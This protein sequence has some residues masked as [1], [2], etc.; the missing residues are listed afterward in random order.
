MKSVQQLKSQF[1]KCLVK[2]CVPGL[3]KPVKRSNSLRCQVVKLRIYHICAAYNFHT[4]VLQ[5]S[6]LFTAYIKFSD[7]R[8]PLTLYCVSIASPGR[9]PVMGFPLWSFSCFFLICSIDIQLMDFLLIMLIGFNQ[10]LLAQLFYL[11]Y[12]TYR[13]I[14]QISS[15]I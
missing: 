1:M 6:A 9:S 15:I 12:R 3:L 4:S 14:N 5:F 8:L 13:K 2:N 10:G 11:F 7:L